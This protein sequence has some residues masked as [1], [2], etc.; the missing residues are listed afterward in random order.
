VP[1]RRLLARETARLLRG[2]ARVSELVIVSSFEPQLLA[3]M[4]LLARGIPR[5]LLVHAGQRLAWTR[6]TPLAARALGCIAV[7]P[8]HTLCSPAIVHGI[9]AAGL[10]VNTW[11]VNAAREANDLVALGVDG[12]ISDDPGAILEAIGAR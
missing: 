3:W 7:H 5:A 2:R 12:I 10:L 8:Q 4:A 1:D 11:T 9:R 6:A